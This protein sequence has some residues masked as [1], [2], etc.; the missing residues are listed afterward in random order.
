MCF[1]LSPPGAEKSAKDLWRVNSSHPVLRTGW[2]LTLNKKGRLPPPFSD[3]LNIFKYYILDSI[4]SRYLMTRDMT[5]TC[6]PKAPGG[7]F[8][9]L[10]QCARGYDSGPSNES[11]FIS[12]WRSSSPSLTRSR[13]SPSH[14]PVIGNFPDLHLGNLIYSN[15]LFLILTVIGKS[16][17]TG[18]GNLR[19]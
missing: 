8:L 4:M 11:A 2:S 9:D 7:T 14:F 5:Y 16:Q 15:R 17:V 12:A 1:G 18:P 13:H 3:A 10:A 19:L 6:P